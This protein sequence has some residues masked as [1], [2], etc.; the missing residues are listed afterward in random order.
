MK[1]ARSDFAILA[2]LIVGAFAL[3]LP[4]FFSPTT[5]S[6][7][8]VVD[9]VLNHLRETTLH[10]TVFYYPMLQANA[11]AAAIVA[12]LG[13]GLAAGAWTWPEVW[14]RLLDPFQFMGVAKAVSF[15]FGAIAIVATYF[16]GRRLLDRRAGL[17][18][19]AI[20]A[21]APTFARYCSEPVP[22]AALAAMAAIASVF[23]LAVLQEPTRRNYALCG[24]FLGLAVSAKYNAA[25]L[26]VA[27]LFVH[28]WLWRARRA[29]LRRLIDSNLLTAVP[30]ALLAFGLTS[31]QVL[32]QPREFFGYLLGYLP[33]ATRSS[34]WMT[35]FV[36]WLSHL[37]VCF[38]SEG[39]IALLFAAGILF[40]LWKRSPATLTL[41]AAVLLAFAYMGRWE[42]VF[43]RYYLF[44]YP[45]LA[46]LAAA[47]VFYAGDRLPSKIRRAP[48]LVALALL[49][50]TVI[51]RVQPARLSL[52]DTRDLARAWIE[53]NI[54]SGAVIAGPVTPEGYPTLLSHSVVARYLDAT[55]PAG[56]R[57]EVERALATRPTYH[58]RSLSF[59]RPTPRFPPE[60]P[61]DVRAR[62]ERN[63][64]ARNVASEDVSLSHLRGKG[65]RFIVLSSYWDP[66][67]GRGLPPYD[68]RSIRSQRFHRF[69]TYLRGIPPEQ[70]R[71]GIRHLVAF[72]G[73]HQSVTGPTI[74]IFAFEDSAPQPAAGLHASA[75]KPSPHAVHQP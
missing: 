13:A 48:V 39:G 20:L 49:G 74:R 10:S 66:G 32:L 21:G 35:N 52:S 3:T 42:K 17:L 59:K 54:P 47:A 55:V 33:D 65:V 25:V 11:V 8:W 61:A 29:P 31:F 18:A 58:L 46:A 50:W 72:P 19:A 60:W 34:G 40:A 45:A 6:G 7:P 71:D 23:L 1:P 4:G 22:D 27:G 16:L 56:L 67:P 44:V 68:L 9:N 73:P 41:L 30:A 70:A 24:L 53:S 69:Y 36:P 28:V 37:K 51:P 12:Y 14:A 64:Y 26:A 2:L 62:Y 63:A 57:P 38:A 75:V 15:V 43:M 5:A